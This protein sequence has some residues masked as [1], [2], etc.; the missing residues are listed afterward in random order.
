MPYR[1][2]RLPVIRLLPEPGSILIEVRA[3]VSIHNPEFRLIETAA[4]PPSRTK[5][6]YLVVSKASSKSRTMLPKMF[7]EALAPENLIEAH[8]AI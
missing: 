7:D 4:V 1:L 6:L 8:F 2:N 5:C 3:S